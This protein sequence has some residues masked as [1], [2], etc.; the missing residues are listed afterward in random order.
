MATTSMK[1]LATPVTSQGASSRFR[2]IRICIVGGEDLNLRIP[3]LKRLQE[4]GLEPVAVG[5][6]CEGPF[7]DHGLR[8]T[9]YRM[10][11]GINPWLDLGTL[12]QL[13]EVF[14]REHPTIVHAFDTKPSI[15]AVWAAHRTRVPIRI[16]T[17]TGLGEVYSKQSFF[18]QTV[19]L[20]L[21]TMHRWAS[22]RAQIT[23]FYNESDYTFAMQHW[24]AR[25]ERAAIVPGSGIDVD[26]FQSRIPPQEV[27]T[28][29][30]HELSAEGGP[31]V[32]MVSRI[33]R[34]KGVFEF[35]A[36][37]KK[38]R[39][40]FPSARFYL[41]GPIEPA[42]RGT[43]TTRQ[44]HEASPNVVWLGWRNDVPALLS[45]ADLLV[46]PTY[47]GEGIP[48]ILLEAGLAGTPVVASEV[49]GCTEVVRHKQNG[50]LVPPRNSEVLA[51][52]ISFLL[53]RPQ[54][55]AELARK[56]ADDVVTKFSLARIVDIWLSIY[57][58]LLADQR[59][60]LRGRF[61]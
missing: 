59:A 5:S 15:Y 27:L 61:S 22:N 18:W 36:A 25:P 4:A 23:V 3:F 26:Q 53:D 51:D 55:R 8:F 1:Q 33:L 24:R 38:V 32:L 12:K 47:Y 39:T 9:K 29:L 19:R 20:L 34:E 16:R 58:R 45:V 44:L 21:T 54:L 40:I 43:I 28:S 7:R 13:S 42:G 2:G 6:G 48:R 11:R 41:V 37:A 10:C 35:L 50:W 31:I 49:P 17:V 30:R 46:L 57:E 56:L 14:A 60:N 52:S